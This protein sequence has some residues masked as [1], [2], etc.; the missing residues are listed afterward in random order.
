MWTELGRGFLK[1]IALPRAGR[2]LT[3]TRANPTLALEGPAGA[4]T[5]T[6]HHDSQ[7]ES[8]GRLPVGRYWEERSVC[9]EASQALLPTPVLSNPALHTL[10][11]PSPPCPHQRVQFQVSTVPGGS[12]LDCSSGVKVRPHSR[13]LWVQ[14]HAA[15]GTHVPLCS[16]WGG[17][18]SSY[19]QITT[20]LHPPTHTGV[21]TWHLNIPAL[22][23]S[24]SQA[25]RA[26]AHS[27][28]RAADASR[29]MG[30][31]WRRP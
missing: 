26:P 30:T 4:Q 29:G 23:G 11:T 8:S 3:H 31:K 1:E 22:R 9:S 10:P 18:G 27:W 5:A 15:G 25:G 17:I 20:S 28:H 2:T 24:H 16:S 13:E 6:A 7:L 14:G 19:T 12:S 21:R